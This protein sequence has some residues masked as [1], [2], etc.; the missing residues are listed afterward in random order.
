MVEPSNRSVE[1]LER[2]AERRDQRRVPRTRL[3][4]AA[5]LLALVIAPLVVHLTQESLETTQST[6]GVVAMKR[7]P[8][9]LTYIIGGS[10]AVGGVGLLAPKAWGWWLTA[11]AAIFGPLDLLR[12]YR[13]LYATLNFDHPDI[14]KVLGKLALLAG[15]PAALY[16][17]LLGLLLARRMRETYRVVSA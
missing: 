14:D 1:R 17:M 12:I 6:Y 8:F 15:I 10:L 3:G 5:G 4:I 13:N 9:L 2:A 16:L 11:I 7:S